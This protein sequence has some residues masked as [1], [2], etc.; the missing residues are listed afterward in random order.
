MRLYT[1]VNYVLLCEK[2]N[3]EAHT[4]TNGTSVD[5]LARIRKEL[6]VFISDGRLEID[7]NNIENQIR[8]IALGRKNFLFAGSHESAQRIAMIYSLLARAAVLALEGASC[9]FSEDSISFLYRFDKRVCD[10]RNS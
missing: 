8:P 3:H 7:N 5:F 1:R 9:T 6:T 2:Q 4:R 10:C